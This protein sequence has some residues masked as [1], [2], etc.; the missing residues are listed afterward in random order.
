[1]LLELLGLNDHLA[2][3][4]D[5]LRPSNNALVVAECY[6][7]DTAFVGGHW[8]HADGDV[9]PRCA[10]G[11]LARHIFD[12]LAPAVAVAFNVHDHRVAET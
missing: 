7:N 2:V 6:V 3:R 1:M 9:L 8:P 5:A 10:I 12:L 4:I 11:G